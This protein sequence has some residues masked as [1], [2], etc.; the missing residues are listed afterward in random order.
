MLITVWLSK[1]RGN[2][3]VTAQAQLTRILEDALPQPLAV[4]IS[5]VA[6][7]R[8]SLLL[9]ARS[10]SSSDRILALNL[11]RT[12]LGPQGVRTIALALRRNQSLQ[13]LQISGC[14]A[15]DT[16]MAALARVIA[17]GGALALTSI[18]CSKFILEDRHQLHR[19]IQITSHRKQSG[20][21][22]LEHDSAVIAAVALSGEHRRF[23]L[24]QGESVKAQGCE[25]ITKCLENNRKLHLRELVLRNAFVGDDGAIILARG[26]AK[27]SSLELLDL[28][29]VT[30]I[31]QAGMAKLTEALAL[32]VAPPFQLLWKK[33]NSFSR[34][35]PCSSAAGRELFLAA[36]IRHGCSQS[37]PSALALD[38][39]WPPRQ[40]SID[41]LSR[42]L[43]LPF[44]GGGRTMLSLTF[45]GPEMEED[46]EDKHEKVNKEQLRYRQQS[47]I[48]ALAN[49]LSN[50]NYLCKLK[51]S[52]GT[53]SSRARLKHAFLTGPRLRPSSDM[54]ASV[55][56]L[57]VKYRLPHELTEIIF[58]FAWDG[59]RYLI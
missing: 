39:S 20:S 51:I 48:D 14:H 53:L 15:G 24:I 55:L 5:G 25:A 31:R 10:L 47:Q 30:R 56:L 36:A 7:S 2:T 9:L 29:G 49:A 26:V 17:S 27:Y 34:S 38:L 6:L 41:L 52:G 13:Q 54:I 45:Y 21:R 33:W 3:S 4:D 16:G 40:L 59:K 12:A 1:D 22:L 19:K 35:A 11:N 18:E 46:H 23:D 32:T 8:N 43:C 44:H 50:S 37:K 58:N 42:L 28:S 57:S